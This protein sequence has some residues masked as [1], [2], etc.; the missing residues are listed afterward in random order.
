MRPLFHQQWRLF[1]PDPPLCSCHIQAQHDD[2]TWHPLF[3]GHDTYLARRT[4]QAVARYVQGAVHA[5]DTIPDEHLLIAMRR[6]AA[7]SDLHPP[8]APL[9]RLIEECVVDPA[10]PWRREERITM[11]GTR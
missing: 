10:Q 8:R 6:M 9:F 11:L 7:G 3:S 2:G 1:A 4:E 5:G